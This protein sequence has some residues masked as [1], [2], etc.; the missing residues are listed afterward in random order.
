MIFEGETPI[1]LQ[2]VIPSIK[3]E[4]SQLRIGLTG[5][6]EILVKSQDTAL[7]IGSGRQKILATPVMITL[8]EAAAQNAVDGHLP[9]GCQTIGTR[10]D[11]QHLAA[12]PEGMRVTATAQLIE[13]HARTLVFQVVVNDE[14]EKIGEGTHER[15]IISISSFTRLLNKKAVKRDVG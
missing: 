2:V 15:A 1:G 4:L 11:V 10:L 8:M 9:D 3:K 13:M 7:H 14:N 5:S 12:T 6:S